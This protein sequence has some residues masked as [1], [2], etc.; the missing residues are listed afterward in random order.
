MIIYKAVNKTNGKVYVGQT[1][2][3]L[4]YRRDQHIRETRCKTHKNTYFHD[5]IQKYGEDNFEFSIIDTADTKEEADEKERYW[6]KYYNS[7][8]K[9]CGYNLVTGGFRGGQ[10]TERA[11]ANIGITTKEKW[12]D[13]KTAEKMR[14][15]LA[16]GVQ[17]KKDNATPKITI[18]PICGSKIIWKRNGRYTVT[19]CSSKCMA[20]SDMWKKGVAA[21]ALASHERNIEQKKQIKTFIHNWCM[22]HQD[23]VL[24]CPKNK[25]STTLTDLLNEIR[26]RYKIKDFRTIFLCYGVHNRKEFLTALQ[27]DIIQSKNVR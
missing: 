12:K 5:A 9:K 10:Y 15:G 19:Y 22:Y 20:K 3:S 2:N 18:C 27:N 6:I 26:K 14:E 23:I 21:S 17:T 25:I 1:K 7:T 8:D 13:P 4:A 16:K 24:K 11:K